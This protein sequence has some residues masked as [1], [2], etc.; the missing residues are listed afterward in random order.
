MDFC[1]VC[2]KKVNTKIVKQKETYKVHGEPIE[3]IADV[4]VCAECG[5]E[6][7]CEELDEKTV[8]T[9]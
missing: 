7:F 2:Y 1:E 3:V 4:K 6:L 8:E 5:E 9:V